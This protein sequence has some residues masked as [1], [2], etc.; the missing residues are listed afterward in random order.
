MSNRKREKK[1]NFDDFIKS[2]SDEQKQMLLSSLQT[3]NV[4]DKPKPK[5]EAKATPSKKQEGITVTENFF[6]KREN[7]ESRGRSPVRARKNQ[8]QDEGEFRDVETPK[9]DR[10]P[11]N[12]EKSKKVEVE[13]HVCG[14][15][16][17]VD[18]R[19]VYGDYQRCNRCVGH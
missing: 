1:M 9:G 7:E 11:R 12:R 17:Q 13:C 8:W 5:M 15:T 10:T 19:Y 18:P 3:Q 16:F 14:R 2:L 4:E 6:V